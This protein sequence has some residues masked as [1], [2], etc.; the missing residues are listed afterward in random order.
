MFCIPKNT[1]VEIIK[2]F[3][4]TY[5]SLIRTSSLVDCK[6]DT[7][8]ELPRGNWTIKKMGFDKPKFILNLGDPND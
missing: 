7:F 6:S 8:L 5:L 1:K 2:T 3:M 4:W